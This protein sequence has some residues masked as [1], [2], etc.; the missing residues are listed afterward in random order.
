MEKGIECIEVTDGMTIV[1]TTERPSASSSHNGARVAHWFK[2]LSG[3]PRNV[4]H[5]PSATQTARDA[6]EA[7]T[8]AGVSTDGEETADQIEMSWKRRKDG[9]RW[10]RGAAHYTDDEQL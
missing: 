9:S 6:W 10:A 8:V 5:H 2:A 7:R 3:H 1:R 4:R